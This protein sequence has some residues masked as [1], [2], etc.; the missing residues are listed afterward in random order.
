MTTSTLVGIFDDDSH[1]RMAAQE[2]KGLGIDDSRITVAR[3]DYPNGYRSYEGLADTAG[4]DHGRGIAAFFRRLFGTDVDEHE[5][6]FYSEAV[7]RGST[8]VT[9]D[10][11]ESLID[12]AAEVLS[13]HGAVDI[14]RRAAQY[15][16]AGF[17]RFDE[18]ADLYSPEQARSEWATFAAQRDVAIPV[19]EE[20]LQ[21]GKRTV[22]RGGVR[23]HTRV[24]ERPVD[25][26][27]TLREEHVRV[28]RRPVD[29][30]ASTADLDI[31]EGR[32][33]D[34]TES[35]EEA[36]VAKRAR[37]V[38]EVIVGKDVDEHEEHVHDTVRRKDVEVENVNAERRVA[39]SDRDLG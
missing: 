27:V 26:V 8:V 25:E 7:R 35:A 5:Q 2:L 28:D 9:V 16:S 19:V 24:T 17:D 6:G 22:N 33:M 36:V 12:N 29:R 15:R 37:V 18:S 1:A 31:M 32:T 10:A 34:I 3:S 39:R 11:D 20:E 30:D 14:D 13:R 21:V 38:E 4:R 23:I